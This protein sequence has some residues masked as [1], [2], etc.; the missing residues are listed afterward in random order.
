MMRKSGKSAGND[1]GLNAV[2]NSGVSSTCLVGKSWDFQVK[3]ALR[4]SLNENLDMISDT[5]T[6]A[7]KR[8]DEV[9]FDAEHFFDGY[10]NNPKYSLNTLK[11]AY[12]AGANWIILCDTNGGTLPYELKDILNQVKKLIPENC[13][14]VHF[15]NDTDN[16]TYNSLES[17]INGATQ[18]QG[19]FNGLGER[20]GN[21]NLVNVAANI[22]LKMKY[23]CKLKKNIKKLTKISRLIDE[24]LNRESSRNLPF[25]GSAAFAHKGGLHISA[26]EKDPK[27]YE[28]I[29]PS[30]VGNERVLVVSNQ[31]RKK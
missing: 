13:L 30:Y 15:H 12:E 5:I 20:C 4:V 18:V 10:K 2:L 16:A 17:V 27:C 7:S 24:T 3:N 25:V 31:S 23:D 14:G 19:T 29:D 21:A 26:V 22:I 1:P 28:H 11:R 9:L 8:L 6:F